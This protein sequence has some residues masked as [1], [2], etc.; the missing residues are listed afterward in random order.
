MVEHQSLSGGFCILSDIRCSFFDHRKVEI[1]EELK[2]RVKEVIEDLIVN[3]NVLIL[4]FGSRVPTG[5]KFIVILEKKRLPY[6]VL[7]KKLST[8]QNI[9]L[10][11]Q[12]MWNETKR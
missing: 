5:K 12:V 1:T 7:K 6:L 3:H 4:L 8:K 10:V 11:E 2:Q 9:H